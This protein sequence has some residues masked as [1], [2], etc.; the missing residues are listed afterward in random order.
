MPGREYLVNGRRY[1]LLFFNAPC[2]IREGRKECW[3]RDETEHDPLLLLELES[4][5]RREQKAADS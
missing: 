4:G 1:R 3:G 2:L 5:N